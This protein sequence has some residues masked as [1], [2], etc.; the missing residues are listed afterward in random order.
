MTATTGGQVDHRE[1][2]AAGA[3]TL[4]E[5]EAIEPLPVDDAA[6]RAFAE[7]AADSR[8]RSARPKLLDA[9][10][11]A[12]ARSRAMPVYTQNADFEAMIGVQVVRV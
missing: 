8:R 1:T 10:I 11:G 6:A 5:V 3:E 4:S 9:L 7:I 2:P 12:T